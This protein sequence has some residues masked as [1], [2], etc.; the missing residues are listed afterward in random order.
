MIEHKSIQEAMLAIYGEVGYVQKQKGQNLNY[1][2]ASEKEFIKA[3]RPS[4]I[5]HGVFMF[6]G[7]MD[8]LNQTEY[9]TGK[10]SLMLRS[11]VHG[12]VTFSHIS[13]TQIT[14][15]A[16]GE[17][18]DSGDKSLNKAMTDIYKYALRQTFMIETGDDP[19]KDKSEP[20]TKKEAD[21]EKTLVW[22]SGFSNES[23]EKLAE[24]NQ[25]SRTQI[26]STMKLCMLPKDADVSELGA[27]FEK[28]KTAR[29]AGN[30]PD[31]SAS[32]ANL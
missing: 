3:L 26:N 4:M 31:A 29:A 28:Y 11:T 30:N 7:K 23:I 17:G 18:S 1:T 19:D 5:E 22:D 27:W 10:G 16:Y 9:T 32:I 2:F 20:V 21:P 12:I 8:Q 25:A 14:V 13:G 24:Q 15:D 6:V